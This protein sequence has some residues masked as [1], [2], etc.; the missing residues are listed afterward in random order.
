MLQAQKQFGRDGTSAWSC[1]GVALGRCLA[2]LLPEDAFDVQPV[3]LPGG[4]RLVGDVRLDNRGELERKLRLTAAEACTLSDSAV[5][6]L[7]FDRWRENCFEHLL[8]EYAFAVWNPSDRSWFL[9]RDP[10]GKRPLFYF[11]NTSLFAF[12]SMP[13]GLHALAE[14]DCAPN[15]DLLSLMV[16]PPLRGFSDE[17]Q[18]A[19]CFLHIRKLGP[20][21]CLRLVDGKEQHW[22]HWNPP[23]A[24]L[25]LKHPEDYRAALRDH[26]DAAVTR[27][28]R[29]TGDV[30]AQLSGGLDSSAV[31]A[32]AA[33]LQAG[34]GKGL[35][36]FT[37]VPRQPPNY[38]TPGYFADEWHHAATVAARHPN[39]EHVRITGADRSPLD[40]LSSNHILYGV[41][42]TNLCNMPWLAEIMNAGRERGLRVML[43]GNS[44]NLTASYDGSGSL[45]ELLRDGHYQVLWQNLRRFRRDYRSSWKSL[46]MSTLGPLLPIALRRALRARRRSPR[47]SILPGLLHP[48]RLARLSP[49]RPVEAR[50]IDSM[51]LRLLTLLGNDPATFSKGTLAQ[52]QMDVRDPLSDQ[53][54][55]EFCLSV[56]IQEYVRDG[57]PGALIRKGLAD[58]LPD[59]VRLEFRRGVQGTDWHLGIEHSALQHEIELL[60]GCANVCAL[61]DIAKMREMVDTWPQGGWQTAQAERP[62]R[63]GLMRTISAASFVRSATLSSQKDAAKPMVAED[64][65]EP[66]TRGF[67][68]PCSTD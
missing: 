20:G 65:I 28:L 38:E 36:A 17:H 16:G 46:A 42:I 64:G 40:G 66:P 61:V 10:L 15:V 63:L 7:A 23:R 59:E 6:G 43:V 31:T 32:T 67:S 25:R 37:G 26:L 49:F 35:I 19:C 39:I 41:P 45:P 13:V 60:A 68:I 1:A 29:G 8:G 33:R 27:C 55:T 57:M 21:R 44:G 51:E 50:F 53:R 24:R 54:L 58:R 9:A 22:R 34:R 56:P 5:L 18:E 52:W 4:L 14:I 30:A 2:R 62:Y 48:D 3:T 11:F 47:P 12:A